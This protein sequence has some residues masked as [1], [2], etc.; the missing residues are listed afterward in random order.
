MELQR[1]CSRAFYRE[2]MSG[3]IDFKCAFSR[4]HTDSGSTEKLEMA[5]RDTRH[6]TGARKHRT[7]EERP[8][9]IGSRSRCACSTS[10]QRKKQAAVF[11]IAG[12]DPAQIARLAT[13]FEASRVGRRWQK[14][15]Q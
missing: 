5:Q 10:A 11:A 2:G 12:A 9:R 8:R 14:G 6:N 3:L 7:G 13:R 15:S 1:S 4:D